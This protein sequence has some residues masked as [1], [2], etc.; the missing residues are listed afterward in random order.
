MEADYSRHSMGMAIA[1]CVVFGL[2]DAPIDPGDRY[3]FPP[4]SVTAEVRTFINLYQCHLAQELTLYPHRRGVINRASSDAEWRYRV[5]DLVD[6]QWCG[7]SDE[8]KAERLQRL[9][10]MIGLEAY[11]R[12][13]LPCP[14]PL[15]AFEELGK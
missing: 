3:R 13:E 8:L 6:D 12:A 11:N 10:R 4:R 1:Y 15:W 9:R 2:L 7:Y 14:V 5:W